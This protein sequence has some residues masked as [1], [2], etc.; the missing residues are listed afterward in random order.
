MPLG[1]LDDAAAVAARLR[2]ELARN[3]ETDCARGRTS[4]GP[5]GDELELVLGTRSVRGFASQGQHRTVVLALKI[6]EITLVEQLV[7]VPPVLL[8]DDVSSELDANRNARLMAWLAAGAHQVFLTTTDPRLVA[9]D[10][11]RRQFHVEAGRVV[12]E[13]DTT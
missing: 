12:L 8:L 11:P 13:E 5:H 7:G 10:G 3:R 6:A 2:E 9:W 1:G 4:V